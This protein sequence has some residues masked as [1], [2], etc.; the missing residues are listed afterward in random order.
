MARIYSS[1]AHYNHFNVTSHPKSKN[2]C[3]RPFT[4]IE[5]MNESLIERWNS[6]VKPDDE[7]QY[8][9]D[10]SL[11]FKAVEEI[12]P[13]LNGNFHLKSGNHDKTWKLKPQCVKKYLDSGFKSVKMIDEIDIDGHG[14]KV[15]LSHL[16]YKPPEALNEDVRYL[17]YRPKDKGLVALVGHVHEKWKIG[18]YSKMINVGVDVWDYYPVSEEELIPLIRSFYG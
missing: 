11:D 15:V 14:H 1:D 2:Y 18:P 12:L 16:P 17:E 3:N 9:G 5:E 13:R 7:V 10:F 4:S 8:L 6:R